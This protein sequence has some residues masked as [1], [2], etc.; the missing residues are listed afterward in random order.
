ML[1]AVFLQTHLLG[2]ADAVQMLHRTIIC[3]GSPSHQSQHIPPRSKTTKAVY[4][5]R[6]EQAREYLGQVLHM[7]HGHRGCEKPL[8][9]SS[10]RH[11]CSHIHLSCRNGHCGRRGHHHRLLWGRS[12]RVVGSNFGGKPAPL[13]LV[14]ATCCLRASAWPPT[15]QPRCLLTSS[16]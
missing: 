16:T 4:W 7:H 10:H 2:S 9:I 15:P 14:K 11:S 5:I 1:T 13:E 8:Q 6:K 3:I 12:Q